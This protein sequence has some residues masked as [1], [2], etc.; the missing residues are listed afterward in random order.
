M[1]IFRDSSKRSYR[2]AA[3]IIFCVFLLVVFVV[4]AYL[5]TFLPQL[6]AKVLLV[7]AISLAVILFAGISLGLSDWI[8]R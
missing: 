5:S 7:V 1:N 2:I 6:F 4:V 8:M 3:S